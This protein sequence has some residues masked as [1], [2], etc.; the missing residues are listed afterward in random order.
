MPLGFHSSET[1]GNVSQSLK[2][3]PTSPDTLR[4]QVLA[5][6]GNRRI[7]SEGTQ[8]T[9]RAIGEQ[10]EQHRL[11]PTQAFLQVTKA[12]NDDVE[13]IMRKEYN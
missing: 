8:K 3:S 6:I 4:D 7:Y 1:S 11:T 12:C 2:S 13:K 10:F 5:I 9:L